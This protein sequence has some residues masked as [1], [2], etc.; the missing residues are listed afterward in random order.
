MKN[1]HKF[2]I[3]KILLIVFCFVLTGCT[4]CNWFSGC[5]WFE[6]CSSHEVSNEKAEKKKDNGRFITVINGTNLVINYVELTTEEG[7][8][9][10]HKDNPNDKAISFE[11]V[12]TWKDYDQFH[13][14]LIDRYELHYEKTIILPKTG[15]VDVK[16]TQDDY[17]EYDGDYWRRLEKKANGD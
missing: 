5:T 8:E 12:D 14:V 15:K 9:I 4:G 6:G 2:N 17:V 10:E 13:I 3:S 7:I 16:I 1:P 11:V